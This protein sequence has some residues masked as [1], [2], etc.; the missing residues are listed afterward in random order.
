M[1]A[2]RRRGLTGVRRMNRDLSVD[3]D[4]SAG[5]WHDTRTGSVEARLI[6]AADWAPIRAFDE[7]M[8]NHADAVYG[9]VLPV[10]RQA[11]LRIVNLECALSDI[12]SPI[13]KSGTVFR[14][15][16]AHVAALATVPFEIAT[17]ANNH[18]LDYGVDSFRQTLDVLASQGIRTVGAGLNADEASRPLI[19]DVQD[20]RLAVVN[21]GE[22]ED[23]TAAG[24]GPGTCGWEPERV[25]DTVRA[26]RAEA[27]IVI[28]I[29]HAGLEYIPCPP[30]YVVR[31]FRRLADAG[32]DLVIGHH[33]HVPQGVEI[34][35]KTPIFY[36]LGNFVFYQETDL[37]Y[38]KI[39]FLVQAEVS[40][41]GVCGGQ[42]IP[43][44]I[45]EQELRRLTGT[46][47]KEFRD[48]LRRVSR[49]LAEDGGVEA[50]WRGFLR[51]YGM[52][53]F[54][55]EIGGILGRMEENPPKGAAMLRN[56]LTTPQHREHWMDFLTRVMEG[57]LEEAP[58]W[59]RD[60]AEEWMTR[61]GTPVAEI[62]V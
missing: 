34:W 31:V 30:P 13:C 12:G 26:V 9:N 24:E 2:R 56:R 36:S 28:V 51:W 17:L 33:P 59:A 18:V 55:N 21:F 42:L 4:W 8:A 62:P 16:P 52:K 7:L 32:A 39:G 58:D 10:L 35:G 3:W 5:R 1:R 47:A 11:D 50:A 38:R 15:R 29:A 19:V 60:L 40:R 37:H 48:V 22:G 46:A 44:A 20:V 57:D 43:Y 49:P 14:G 27:D 23:L 25:A 54:R 6:I 41:R 61:R 45:G 53:G